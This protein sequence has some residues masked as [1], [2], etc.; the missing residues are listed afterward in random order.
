M[1]MARAGHVRRRHG[2]ENWMGGSSVAGTARAGATEWAIRSPLD[3]TAVA[4]RGGGVVATAGTPARIIRGRLGG[5][6]GTH[7]AC[8]YLRPCRV[9]AGRKW[10]SGPR[11]S[12]VR[13]K[14]DR[15]SRGHVARRGADTAKH[16]PHNAAAGLPIYPAPAAYP[17]AT[18]IPRAPRDRHIKSHS[19]RGYRRGRSYAR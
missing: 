11:A 7:Q 3:T 8:V 9:Q 4:G 12:H 16:V 15:G 10:M 19:G 1:A 13:L 2:Y 17:A 5:R 18:S 14:P 6:V